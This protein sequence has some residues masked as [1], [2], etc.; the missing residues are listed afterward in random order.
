[1]PVS[2]CS[3]LSCVPPKR[4]VGL[5]TPHISKGGLIGERLFT[6]IQVKRGWALIQM[7]GVRRRRNVDTDRH[8]GRRREETEGR[9]A[10]ISREESR[11]RAFPQPRKEP[12]LLT[13]GPQT[14]SL[15][16]WETIISLSKPLSSWCFICNPS[17]GMQ[18]LP[19]SPLLPPQ[20]TL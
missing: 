16:N 18:I 15:Q 1:M 5:L 2:P 11:N 4:Y 6:E 20:P 10:S 3:G 9:Q 7:T 13:P 17:E 14:A 19:L 8:R 12:A